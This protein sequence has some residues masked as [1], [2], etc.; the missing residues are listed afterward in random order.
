M[1][2]LIVVWFMK[3]ISRHCGGSPQVYSSENCSR[4]ESRPFDYGYLDQ[5]NTS[6]NPT[7]GSI[8]PTVIMK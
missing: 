2:N 3:E 6:V 1:S 5:T 7:I 4:D 8:G